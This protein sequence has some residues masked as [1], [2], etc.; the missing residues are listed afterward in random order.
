MA[1]RLCMIT[2]GCRHRAIYD[3]ISR[4]HDGYIIEKVTCCY[5]CGMDVINANHECGNPLP[6]C[7]ITPVNGITMNTGII[8]DNR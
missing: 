7:V 8:H 3:I 1:C 6:D 4:D 2:D 5:G